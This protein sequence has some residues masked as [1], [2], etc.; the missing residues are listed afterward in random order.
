MHKS[1]RPREDDKTPRTAPKRT[2]SES[3]PELFDNEA[4]RFKKRPEL[5]RVPGAGGELCLRFAQSIALAPKIAVSRAPDIF[6]REGPPGLA[7]R[8]RATGK[9]QPPGVLRCSARAVQRV[10]N[11]TPAGRERMRDFSKGDA[12]VGCGKQ[13]AKRIARRDFKIE[14]AGEGQLAHVGTEERSAARSQPLRSQRQHLKRDV[15]TDHFRGL[16]GDRRHDSSQPRAEL[17]NETRLPASRQPRPE[18]QVGP[19]CC[20][21]LVKR[22]DPAV[23]RANFLDILRA[24][25]AG[26]HTRGYIPPAVARLLF[27]TGTPADVRGGSGTYVGISVLQR[28]VEALGHEV[29]LLAPGSRGGVSLLRRVFFNIRARSAAGRWA[30]EVIV[31]FDW[32]GLFL[33]RSGG[34]VHIASIKGVIAE[35][36]IFERGIPW[37]RLTTEAFLEGRH[38]RRADRILAT[39]HH[40]AERLAV[41]YGLAPE[42][43]RVVPEPIDLARWRKALEDAPGVPAETP[44]ILCVAHLYPRKDVATL[45][46]AIARLPVATL[47]VVG[48]GAEL[49]R[50]QKQATRLQLADRVQFLGHVSFERLAAEYKRAH[51]FCLPSRQEGFGIVFLEAMAAGLPIIA[52]R[53]A[54]VPEVVADGECGILVPPGDAPALAEALEQLLADA[55]ERRRLGDAGRR[56]VER[57]DAP[58]VAALFLE[59]IG[60]G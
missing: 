7:D 37:L 25:C 45:L 44:T 46:D 27:V 6:L 43:L 5:P 42:L 32:D 54:A 49:A 52:A 60:A 11:E 24:L 19:T 38:V 30:P 22:E 9:R 2:A 33:A 39:S 55:K 13:V 3:P 48:T 57:Y 23:V 17:E 21:H 20:L 4:A 58:K 8:E 12:P 26:G 53:A 35:E 15:E 51:V 50:L 56:R 40:S 28:A 1:R 41:D 31:A 10:E 36:A 34:A 18:L 47:R 59:A 29:E 16:P 14:R